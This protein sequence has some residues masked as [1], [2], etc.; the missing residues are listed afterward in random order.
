VRLVACQPSDRSEERI[1]FA[2][3]LLD[4]TDGG[5]VGRQRALN[6]ERM[7]RGACQLR[8][9]DR[10]LE[11]LL[12][13]RATVDGDEDL[14]ERQNGYLSRTTRVILASS[15]SGCGCSTSLEL[16]V[17]AIVDQCSV[18]YMPETS[19]P[20]APRI[21]ANTN[22]TSSERATNEPTP[23]AIHPHIGIATFDAAESNSF[24]A[25]RSRRSACAE[26][27]YPR[28]RPTRSLLH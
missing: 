20:I 26:V 6:R 13:A 12:A 7:Q 10:R 14:L 24:L 27:G 15:S 8:Q 9:L 5:G 21:R 2:L 18:S 25:Q 19:R 16:L 4:F 22:P 17:G 11:C 28:C 3:R 1:F 23:I